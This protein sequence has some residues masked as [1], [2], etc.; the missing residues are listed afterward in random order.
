[1]QDIKLYCFLWKL[2]SL[3]NVI[4][5][6]SE[7]KLEIMLSFCDKLQTVERFGLLNCKNELGRRLSKEIRNLNCLSHSAF[8]NQ[9]CP[10]NHRIQ[11][12]FT[13][14]Y[15]LCFFFVLKETQQ[16]ALI[17]EFCIDHL[18]IPQIIFLFGSN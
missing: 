1:M 16:F 6:K 11:K 13:T 5:S 14:L 7:R 18:I 17:L 4:S 9:S 8:R 2:L 10:N 15:L 12:A 3:R